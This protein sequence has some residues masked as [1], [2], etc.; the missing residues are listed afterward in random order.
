MKINDFVKECHQTARDNGFWDTGKEVGTFIALI[1]SEVS[2]ALEAD[3]CA[4]FVE[5][6]ADIC[7]WIGD[8]CGGYDINLEARLMEVA[9]MM[10]EDRPYLNYIDTASINGL[11]LSIGYVPPDFDDNKHACNVHKCLSVALEADRI[12]ESEDF[13]LGIAGA[14]M[15]TFIWAAQK[16]YCLEDAIEEKMARNKERGRLHGKRY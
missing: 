15:M 8:L 4:E 7:I 11:E 16:G 14:F 10:K 12:G 6:L 9:E 5:E 1:H 13:G 3:S 2:E